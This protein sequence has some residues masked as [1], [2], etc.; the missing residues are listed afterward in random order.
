MR[1]SSRPNLVLEESNEFRGKT[2]PH[3]YRFGL[4]VCPEM[5]QSVE[6][7]KLFGNFWED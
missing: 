7:F 3:G 4:R 5:A 2:V 6:L 1:A